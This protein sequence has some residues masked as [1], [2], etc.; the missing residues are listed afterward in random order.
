MKAV[1]DTRPETSYDDDIVRRYHFPNRYLAEA[2]KS[3]GDWI[4]YREPQRGG[5]RRGYIG[6][7][8]V[9]DIEA[10]SNDTASSYALVSHFLPFD[11]VVP[12]RREKGFY[13]TW[14]ERDHRP[15][16]HRLPT[17]GEVHPDNLGRGVQ[18]DHARRV[19]EHTGPRGGPWGTRRRGSRRRDRP[20]TDPSIK[21][22][23]RATHRP[24]AGEPTA[25]RRR[26]PH[27]CGRGIQT[28]MRCHRTADRQRRRQS[29]ST[30]SAHLVRRRRR[31]GH[32]AKRHRPLRDLPLALRPP[33]HQPQ[34]RLRTA[35]VAQQ[36]A[37]RA[38]EPL[39]EANRQDPPPPRSN[40]TGGCGRD[41]TS[42]PGT[43]KHSRATRCK[44]S[45][46]RGTGPRPTLSASRASAV[47]SGTEPNR[48]VRYSVARNEA[49]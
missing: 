27:L 23:S 43:G 11:T 44:P 46:S 3:V 28:N 15:L 33:P 39:R 34:G 29:R 1:F 16:A 20:S 9:T 24:N 7:A 21:G 38:P 35:R 8:H 18:C 41:S 17:P 12:L 49:D 45:R 10:D 31:P 40:P 30:G 19:R 42:S 4:V 47:K 5:G 26:I 13:E 6:V 36:G 25:Q 14:A 2:R 48:W 32:R 22:R 37:E